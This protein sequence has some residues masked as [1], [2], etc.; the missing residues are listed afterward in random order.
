MASAYYLFSECYTNP[1]VYQKGL[2]FTILTS[3]YKAFM[4]WIYQ[5]G[6]IIGNI[7][8]KNLLVANMDYQYML[9]GG[10]SRLALIWFLDDI[11][12]ALFFLLLIR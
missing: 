10:N 7:K 8:N 11:I 9:E 12:I 1:K 5:F 6:I 3:I 2:W 4:I